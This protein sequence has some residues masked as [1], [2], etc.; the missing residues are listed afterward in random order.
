MSRSYVELQNLNVNG[1]SSMTQ[2]RTVSNPDF[3]YALKNLWKA[4]PQRWRDRL[5]GRVGEKEGVQ[6]L[7][8]HAQECQEGARGVLVDRRG[9][10]GLPQ[11]RLGLEVVDSSLRFVESSSSLLGLGVQLVDS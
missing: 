2:A 11:D 6:Y 7:L 8:S 3:D 9:M 10:E 5:R 1:L 4:L